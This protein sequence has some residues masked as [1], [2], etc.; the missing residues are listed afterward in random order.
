MRALVDAQDWFSMHSTIAF[1]C[2]FFAEV[3]LLKVAADQYCPKT[4]PQDLVSL[5][6]NALDWRQTPKVPLIL[7]LLA[8][9][10]SKFVVNSCHF[11]VV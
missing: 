6:V 3:I 4:V 10:V 1:A 7:K 9:L 8:N 11:I 5:I 2:V